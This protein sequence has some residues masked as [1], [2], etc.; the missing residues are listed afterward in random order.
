[1]PVIPHLSCIILYTFV[2]S[3]VDLIALVSSVSACATFSILVTS[4]FTCLCI[5][6]ISSLP[7]L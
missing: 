2:V 7:L 4:S 6:L 3:S 5:S 1:M